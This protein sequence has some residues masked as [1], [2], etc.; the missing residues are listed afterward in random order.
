[1]VFCLT[2][3]LLERTQQETLKLFI[4]L[5]CFFSHIEHWIKARSV[6]NDPTF[7]AER[8]IRAYITISRC[9]NYN[10]VES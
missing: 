2:E 9:T 6:L 7:L 4:A 10:Y 8:L 5:N 3:S 1:M